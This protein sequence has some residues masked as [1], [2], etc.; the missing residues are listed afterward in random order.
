M[1]TTYQQALD[2]IAYAEKHGISVDDVEDM[3][4]E[5]V[6]QYADNLDLAGDCQYDAWKERGT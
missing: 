1:K 5:E 6:I 2:E 4:E 3:T